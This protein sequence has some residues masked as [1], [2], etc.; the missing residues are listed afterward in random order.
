MT[1]LSNK[2]K[3]KWQYDINMETVKEMECYIQIIIIDQEEKHARDY[4][5]S[6]PAGNYDDAFVG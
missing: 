4:Y 2:N 5:Q 6:A 3:N 1:K